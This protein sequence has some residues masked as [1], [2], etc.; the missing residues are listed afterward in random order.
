MPE[1]LVKLREREGL[2]KLYLSRWASVTQ[3][4]TTQLLTAGSLAQLGRVCG[5]SRDFPEELSIA[6]ANRWL[7]A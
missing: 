1:R 6:T 2:P 7:R 4:R 3:T 5:D